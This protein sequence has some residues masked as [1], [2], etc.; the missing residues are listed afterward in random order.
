MQKKELAKAVAERV[1][2]NAKPADVV[3]AVF[4]V[5]AEKVFE[6]EEVAIRGFGKFYLKERAERKGRNPRTGEEIIIPKHYKMAFVPY[7]RTKD[8]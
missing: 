2:K 1:G 3:D 6:G 5:I 4:D 8:M 7:K